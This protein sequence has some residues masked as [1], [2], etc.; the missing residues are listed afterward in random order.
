MNKKL[1]TFIALLSLAVSGCS[2]FSGSQ[3]AGLA[4]IVDDY[5]R[6]VVLAGPALRVITLEPASTEIVFALGFG[7]RIV[8]A[9]EYSDYPE[10]AQK[11]PRVGAIDAPNLEMIVALEPDLVFATNMHKDT[12]EALEELGI[13]SL[14]LDPENIDGIFANIR[15]IAAA[16]GEDAAGENLITDMK[17]RLDAV[18]QALE[19]LT[20]ERLPIVFYEVWYPGIISAGEDTFIHEMIT[21]A[22]GKNLAWGVSRWENI[23]E[24]EIL[25]RNPDIIVHGHFSEDSAHF[26]EREGWEVVNAIRQ[27][28]VYFINPDLTSRTGPR[29]V[30]AVE[31]M[32]RIFHPDRFE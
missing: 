2:W 20:E 11:I 32:A 29:V 8:G 22:G 28:K 14:A 31:I 18:A 12:V 4:P 25:Q 17:N 16:L 6:E 1:I 10:A 9:T 13:A 15:L 5:G 21:R 24:E 3:P 7:D 27:E 26:Y 23:Q 30:D 19:G